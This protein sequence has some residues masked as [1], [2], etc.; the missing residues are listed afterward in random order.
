M[1]A[2]G[3]KLVPAKTAAEVAQHVPLTPGAKD[4]LDPKHT[5]RQFLDV[6]ISRQLVLDALK[7]LAYCLPKREAVWWALGCVGKI[8]A[9]VPEPAAKALQ[10]AETWVKQPSEDHRR[11]AQ[12]AGETAGMEHPGGIVATAVFL[13]DGSLGPPTSPPVPPGPYLTAAAV[14]GAVNVAAVFADPDKAPQKH[15]LFL[16]LGIE[17]ANG[18]NRWPEPVAPP[19]APPAA[20]APAAKRR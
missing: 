3:L 2:D 17:I 6:L 14:A 10:A 13:A 5:P 4:A 15:A 9:P 19:P 18:T 7:F 16:A 8:G 11:A 20:P 1:S 12:A